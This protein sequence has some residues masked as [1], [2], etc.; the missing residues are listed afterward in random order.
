METKKTMHGGDEDKKTIAD[1]GHSMGES[2]GKME[3]L[4]MRAEEE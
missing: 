3:W 1:E 2:I 4:W